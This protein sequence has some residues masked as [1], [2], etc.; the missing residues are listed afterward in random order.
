MCGDSKTA[1]LYGFTKADTRFAPIQ[2][3]TT[4]LCNDVSH[5]LC[6]SVESALLYYKRQMFYMLTYV[7]LRYS[8][9]VFI[10]DVDQFNVQSTGNFIISS[11]FD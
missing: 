8:L 7:D 3:E 2:W 5:W 10:D 4:L 1:Y 9:Y 6:A 11:V